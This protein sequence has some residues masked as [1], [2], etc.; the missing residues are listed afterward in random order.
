LSNIVMEAYD[1][2]FF[3]PTYK[4]GKGLTFIVGVETVESH[5]V[6]K[7]A[8]STV[9]V[10]LNTSTQIISELSKFLGGEVLILDGITYAGFDVVD[11]DQ[12]SELTGKGIIVIQLYPLDLNRIKIAL[13]KHFTDW[14]ERYSVIEEVYLKMVYFNTPWR[15]IRVYAKNIELRKVFHLLKSTCIYS[16]IPEPLRIADKLASA[17]SKLSSSRLGFV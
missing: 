15:T 8:W 4:S 5:K 1:D 6:T 13:Q 2:G 11:P 12:L 16:P 10:D 14:R 3:P 17:L 7:I 9:R